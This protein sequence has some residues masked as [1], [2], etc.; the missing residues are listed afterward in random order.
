MPNTRTENQTQVHR[1]PRI[2]WANV[3]CL[4]DSSSGASISARAM[5]KQLALKGYEIQIVSAGVFDSPKGISKL[6]DQWSELKAKVGEVIKI[7]DESLTHH[8]LMTQ[9]TQRDL[10]TSHEETLWFNLYSHMLDTFRPDLVFY[11][12][13]QASDFHVATEARNRAIPVMFYLVN[14]NYGG[15]R[16]CQDVDLIITDSQATAHMYRENGD[17]TVYPVGTFIEPH[18]VV[19]TEHSRERVL[20][21]NPSLEKGAGIV[22][23]LAILLAEQRPDIQF[24]VVESRGNWGELVKLVSQNAMGKLQDKLTNV[25]V[26]PNTSDMR[27]IYGRARMLLAPSLWWESGARVLAEA[28]L[29]G[30][31]AIVT[32]FGGSPEMIQD[33]GI[34]LALPSECHTKPFINLPKAELLQP[35]IDRVIR[36]YDDPDYY[37]S[38][39]AKASRVGQTT[40]SLERNTERLIQAIAPHIRKQAGDLDFWSLQKAMNKQGVAPPNLSQTKLEPDLLL[41]T[42]KH[43]AMFEPSSKQ[44]A[45]DIFSVIKLSAHNAKLTIGALEKLINQFGDRRMGYEVDL[46]SWENAGNPV[47]L[48]AEFAE[49][50]N[51]LGSDKANPHQYHRLYGQLL[52]E[53]KNLAINLLEIGLGSTNPNLPSNMGSQATPGSSLRAFKEVLSMA[54]IYGA[55]IDR[56]I[57]FSEERIQTYFVDQCDPQSLVDLAAALPLLDMIIDDGLHSPGANLNTLIFALTKLRPGGVLVIEDIAEPVLPIWKIITQIIPQSYPCQLIKTTSAHVFVLRVPQKPF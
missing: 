21:I 57:L 26:T 41:D 11:Y 17:Y 23:Q 5:L 18:T 4:L 47:E 50:F 27:P 52:A 13:G 34:K 43:L 55:D 28:M 32:D 35:L 31:P 44:W 45:A 36:L 46:D 19:S 10:M 3:H 7:N 8:L 6:Q 9:N 40:H 51:R 42:L 25:I 54:N 15:Y 48:V 53:Q 2:L 12:G 30:I 29:N 33:G 1:K 16:W 49:A 20:F 38:L 37:V 39:C 14:G 22:I 56:S 24:E